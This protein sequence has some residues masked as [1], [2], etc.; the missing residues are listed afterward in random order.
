[1]NSISVRLRT[2]PFP[3]NIQ[4]EAVEAA[5]AS[6]SETAAALLD[7]LGPN[8]PDLPVLGNLSEDLGRS[9]RSLVSRWRRLPRISPYREHAILQAL[10]V[11]RS[12]TEAADAAG[13]AVQD[14]VATEDE[15]GEFL[16][17]AARLRVA[18]ALRT[19]RKGTS[20][21][22][23]AARIG[24]AVG[25]LSELE[26]GQAGLPSDEVCRKLDGALGTKVEPVV[27]DARLRAA[28]LKTRS[29]MRR[30]RRGSDRR[31]GAPLGP[32]DDARLQAVVTALAADRSLLEL[33][34]TLVTL[35]RAAR[36]G[37]QQL[38]EGF[39]DAYG[40]HLT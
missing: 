28:E 18:K 22:A 10:D 17:L 19:A 24:L 40:P 15:V 33:T 31:H 7:E 30:A 3:A 26:G 38:L 5:L 36:R 9:A 2:S 35:P 1:V 23:A 27:K 25:Y 8:T 39:N 11:L 13:A 32:R 4:E 6:L 20:L 29:R 37:V 21:R 16:L 34:E 12:V 14:A